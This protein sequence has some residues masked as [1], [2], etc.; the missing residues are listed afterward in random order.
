[1]DILQQHDIHL[2][3]VEILIRKKRLDFLQKILIMEDSRLVKQVAFSEALDGKR[4]CGRPLISWRQALNQDIK[5][6]N[7]QHILNETLENQISALKPARL[8]NAAHEANK[9]W[10]L[11]RKQKSE[12]RKVRKK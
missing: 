12:S 4:N 11:M 9:I 5:I 3:S 8:D 1:M 2:L 6:F 7:L 10:K